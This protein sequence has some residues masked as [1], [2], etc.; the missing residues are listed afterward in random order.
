MS[1]E[2]SRWTI[3]CG[4]DFFRGVRLRLN[5]TWGPLIDL[6]DWQFWCQARIVPNGEVI[7]NF[8]VTVDGTDL[9]LSL[10]A[11]TTSALQPATCQVDL[12]AQRPDGV[13]IRLFVTRATISPAI[14]IPV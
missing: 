10:D 13:R 6:T 4:A 8:D 3:E 14:T 1:A 5:N 11:E 9:A 2:A 7:A 12:L